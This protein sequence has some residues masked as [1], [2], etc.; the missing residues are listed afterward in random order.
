MENSKTISLVNFNL[1][2]AATKVDVIDVSFTVDEILKPNFQ[3]IHKLS[4]KASIPMFTMASVKPT[5]AIIV[6]TLTYLLSSLS[7]LT[8]STFFFNI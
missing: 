7:L 2:L 3:H 5:D 8:V 6:R 1:F 4:T